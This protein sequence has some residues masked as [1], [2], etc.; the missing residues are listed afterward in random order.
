LAI[1]LRI[2]E[3]WMSGNPC[4]KRNQDWRV[5]CFDLFAKENRDIQLDGS[6]PGIMERR[7]MLHQVHVD[8]NTD[9]HRENGRPLSQAQPPIVTHNSPLPTPP[10]SPYV[11]ALQQK[12]GQSPTA[13]EG[14]GSVRS[15]IVQPKARRKMKRIVDLDDKESTDE[16]GRD[17]RSRSTLHTRHSTDAGVMRLKRHVEADGSPMGSFTSDNAVDKP[18]PLAV[19]VVE[20]STTASLFPPS[21]PSGTISV[22]RPAIKANRTLS[23]A[24][25][26][27]NK[28]RARMSPSM[29]EPPSMSERSDAEHERRPTEG[30]SEIVSEAQLFRKRI[31]ALRTEVGD[32]WLKVLSQTHLTSSDDRH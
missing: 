18:V 32:S 13:T 14:Q 22:A 21:D 12:A 27:S 24:T 10:S 1:L 16:S 2:K 6:S 5:H 30:S 15:S 23:S 29:F 7:A 17:T 19:T 11:A 28:R 8:R 26:K 25:T 3:I 4:T 31:E 20:P 9:S